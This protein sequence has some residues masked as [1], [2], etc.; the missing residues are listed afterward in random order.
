[1]KICCEQNLSIRQLRVRIKSNEYERLDED[2][3]QELIT[4]EE[5]NVVDFD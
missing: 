5:D 4:K 2:T 3:K 1:M